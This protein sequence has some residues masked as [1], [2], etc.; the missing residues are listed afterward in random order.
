MKTKTISGN[1]AAIPETTISSP[2]VSQPTQ[3][4]L[5]LPPSQQQLAFDQL[6]DGRHVDEPYVTLACISKRFKMGERTI[7]RNVREYGM[8][9]HMIGKRGIRFLV[10]EVQR[11]LDDN[12]RKRF[13][14]NGR[15]A[16]RAEFQKRIVMIPILD[17]FDLVDRHESKVA[18]ADSGAIAKR[19]TSVDPSLLPKCK[20]GRKPQSP[21]TSRSCPAGHHRWRT[22]KYTRTCADCGRTEERDAT[23]NWV[24][25]I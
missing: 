15:A 22:S 5:P 8:P 16:T 9:C 24:L 2:V 7:R 19:A 11:W 20:P 23:N 10:T 21:D 17:G 1:K 6:D 14:A 3:P 18:S 25:S 12:D 13:A 4:Q